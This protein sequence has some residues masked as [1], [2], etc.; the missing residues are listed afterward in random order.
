M[1]RPS[2][3]LFCGVLVIQTNEY[4]RKSQL[5]EHD[6][7]SPR[8]TGRS[9]GRQNRP[10]PRPTTGSWLLCVIDV[11]SEKT[12]S[13]FF[14]AFCFIDVIEEMPRS[15]TQLSNRPDRSFNLGFGKNML[16]E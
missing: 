6:F 12:I 10:Q 16:V 13:I 1:I 11:V 14:F 5:I 3:N 4:V 7:P 2:K 15:I 8:R 9:S